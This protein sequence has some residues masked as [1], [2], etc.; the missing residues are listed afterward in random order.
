MTTKEIKRKIELHQ[1]VVELL[2][3][4]IADMQKKIL[5]KRKLMWGTEGR[6]RELIQKMMGDEKAA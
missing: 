1:Q 4:E 3:D 2:K 6:V 5:R